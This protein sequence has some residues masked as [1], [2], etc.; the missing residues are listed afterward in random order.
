MN[1]GLDDF[2]SRLNLGLLILGPDE[3]DS[4]INLLDFTNKNI[5][6]FIH[7]RTF[8]KCDKDVSTFASRIY[9]LSVIS[10]F[11]VVATNTTWV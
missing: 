4:T 5:T 2:S 3:L 10:I 9:L 1:F 8:L 7:A 11:T 6:H